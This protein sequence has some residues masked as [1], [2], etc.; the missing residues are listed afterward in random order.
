MRCTLMRGREGDLT[1]PPP[2]PLPP[3]LTPLPT[4]ATAAPPIHHFDLYTIEIQSSRLDH[5]HPQPQ[6]LQQ[7]Q[8]EQQQHQHQ[9]QQSLARPAFPSSFS[10]DV[11][12]IEWLERPPP[13]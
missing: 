6:E 8:Q 4:F 2:S 11:S 1:P 12:L 3:L 7:Q 10:A 13:Q 5:T 9:H